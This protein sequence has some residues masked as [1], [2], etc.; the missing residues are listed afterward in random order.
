MKFLLHCRVL[1]YDVNVGK[2]FPQF[3]DGIRQ[4]CLQCF[5]GDVEDGSHFFIFELVLADEFES[6]LAFGG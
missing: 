2:C 3:A 6:H 4:V 5:D 1:L